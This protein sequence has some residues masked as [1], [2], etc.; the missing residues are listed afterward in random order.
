MS[1]APCSRFFLS[2]TSGVLATGT[3][4]VASDNC[5]SP[6]ITWPM[7]FPVFVSF[8]LITKCSV[9]HSI[10]GFSSLVT[11]VF[12]AAGASAAGVLAVETSAVWGLA[13]EVLAVEIFAAWWLGSGALDA[14]SEGLV[15]T[16]VSVAALI[17][18]RDQDLHRDAA[19]PLLRTDFG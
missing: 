13:A 19:V 16:S 9:S 11:A 3:S 18:S 12:W 6:R 1:V 5:S 7:L 2:V 17:G 14:V 10:E 4:L 8:S 15:A